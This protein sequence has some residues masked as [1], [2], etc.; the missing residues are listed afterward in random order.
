MTLNN[1]TTGSIHA[2]ASIPIWVL[3]VVSTEIQLGLTRLRGYMV[4]IG[5]DPDDPELW[6]LRQSQLL[7]LFTKE[8]SRYNF[9]LNYGK[10]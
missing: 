4:D 9:R 5:E 6:K 3:D 7:T 2:T 8:A 1:N 10:E